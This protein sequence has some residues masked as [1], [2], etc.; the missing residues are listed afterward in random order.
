MQQLVKV[1]FA[2]L[3]YTI[4]SQTISFSVSTTFFIFSISSLLT[5]DVLSPPLSTSPNS[6]SFCFSIVN[7]DLEFVKLLTSGFLFSPFFLKL[8]PPTLYNSTPPAFSVHY[9]SSSIPSAN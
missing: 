9:L 7:V 4:L 3:S 6:E 2:S 5:H 8:T 1:K